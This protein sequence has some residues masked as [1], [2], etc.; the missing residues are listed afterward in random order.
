MLACVADDG[1][2]AAVDMFLAN[3][4]DIDTQTVAVRGT[5]YDILFYR[6]WVTLT[7]V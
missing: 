2:L 1:D 3:G 7:Q 4:A 5:I 6:N